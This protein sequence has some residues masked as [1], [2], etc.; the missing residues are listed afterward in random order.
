MHLLLSVQ[1]VF[2][3]MYEPTQPPSQSRYRT[4][5]VKK[6]G[7]YVQWNTTWQQYVWT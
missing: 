3:Q 2:Q 1:S 6:R 5:P 7:K 4:L